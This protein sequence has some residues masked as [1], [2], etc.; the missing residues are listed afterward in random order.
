MPAGTSAGCRGKKNLA[1][2]NGVRCYFHTLVVGT[3]FHCFFQAK[4]TCLG[5]SFG[6]ICGGRA[7]IRQLLFLGDVD[8]HILRAGVLPHDDTFVDSITRG[9]EEISTVCQLEQRVGCHL[10]GPVRH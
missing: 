4:R 1:D 9:N 6:L 5:E 2:A 8:V 10:A 7:H 3:E